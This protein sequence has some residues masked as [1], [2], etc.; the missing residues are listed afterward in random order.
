MLKAWE[1]ELITNQANEDT[2]QSATMTHQDL[3][4]Y[5]AHLI[6]MVGDKRA[7]ILSYKKEKTVFWVHLR[8]DYIAEFHVFSEGGVHKLTAAFR[9]FIK[10]IWGVCPQIRIETR[11][12]KPVLCAILK[13]S[14]IP[15]EGVRRKAWFD[16]A[17][18]EMID[19]NVYAIHRP[20][21]TG[22][23]F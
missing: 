9:K 11:V 17:T 13:R 10:E 22:Y 15:I 18:Q 7:I 8:T 4:A 16:K 2:W 12:R 6:E 5:Q 20:N 21:T 3:D 1:L 23:S 14:G 19:E